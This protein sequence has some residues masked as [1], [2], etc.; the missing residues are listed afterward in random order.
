MCMYVCIYAAH[1]FPLLS[2]AYTQIHTLP[3]TLL[4]ISFELIKAKSVST[5][6]K[7][8]CQPRLS[9]EYYTSMLLPFYYFFFFVFCC[10]VCKTAHC[11]NFLG[12]I[13]PPHVPVHAH[14]YAHN[15][16]IVYS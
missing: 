8:N 10:G 6:S 1:S 11:D 15:R 5:K 7:I 13:L 12:Q 9:T 14:T 16:K 4:R 3:V 2:S